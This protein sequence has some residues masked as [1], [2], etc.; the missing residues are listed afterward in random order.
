MPEW[1][2]HDAMSG[3]A[4]LLARLE[5]EGVSVAL[6]G[7]GLKL[8]ADHAPPAELLERLKRH[9]A[10]VMAELAAR[11]APDDPLEQPGPMPGSGRSDLSEINAQEFFGVT[12]ARELEHWRACNEA[13]EPA[14]HEGERLKR[15]AL[16]F[17]AD[18]WAEKALELGWSELD[19]F[20]LVHWRRHDGRG[21][22]VTAGLSIH[23]LRIIGIGQEKARLESQTGAGMT[24]ARPCPGIGQ[25]RPFWEL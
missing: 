13:L 20:G 1:L 17:L 21:L 22:V 2:E 15:A 7:D 9:K 4:D 5:A 3:A 23:R 10:E 11:L 25:A 19:L 8:K 6:D 12:R 16:E 14:C 18:G 24:Y